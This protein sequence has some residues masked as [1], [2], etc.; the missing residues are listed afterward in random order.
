MHH[1]IF[2]VWFP[3]FYKTQQLHIYTLWRAQF[4]L[5]PNHQKC[6]PSLYFI[7][8]EI[9]FGWWI[10][11]ITVRSFAFL[12]WLETEIRPWKSSPNS[13][14]CRNKKKALTLGAIHCTGYSIIKNLWYLWENNQKIQKNG[15]LLVL[16][17]DDICLRSS[18]NCLI[19]CKTHYHST[20]WWF[21]PIS[22]KYVKMIHQI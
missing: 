18:L 3:S 8:S 22:N 11:K 21:S 5:S 7:T 19:Q 13:N 2:S 1:A 6:N 14:I 9:N 10:T 16:F 20:S 4:S 12:S 15:K 17:S